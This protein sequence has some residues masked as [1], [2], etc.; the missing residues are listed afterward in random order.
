MSSGRV[1]QLNHDGYPAF[2]GYAFQNES[3]RM[4]CLYK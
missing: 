3:I 2:V 1:G 4:N